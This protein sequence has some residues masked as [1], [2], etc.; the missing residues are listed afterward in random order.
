MNRIN[1]PLI[2]FDEAWRCISTLISPLPP[3]LQ[4]LT[5]L[6]GYVLAEEVIAPED[7]PSYPTAAMDGYAIIAADSAP[8][9]HII[10]EQTAGRSQPVRVEIGTAVRIMTGAP[11]P[12]GADAVIR[13]EESEEKDGMVRF[14]SA[15]SAGENI[16]PVGQDLAAGVVVLPLG[17]V[18]G[19]AEIGLL[20]SIGC[21]N[22]RV[23]PRP[24]V[25][26]MAT[27]SELVPPE[28]IPIH[29]K[30]R[31]SNSYI[32]LAAVAAAGGR[33][34]HLGIIPDSISAQRAAILDGIS[35]ADMV[36][37]SGGV[38]MGTHD[39][40]KPLLN[41][42]G[43][44]HFGQV[45]IKPGK[46]FTFATVNN[47]PVF[48][49]PGFPVSSFVVVE[50]F[51]RPALRVMAGHRR[52]W[53]PTCT[54][55]LRHTIQHAPDRTE[56]QRAVVIEQDHIY[57]AETT[58]IQVSSRLQSLVGANA[59]LRIPAGVADLSAGAEVTAL[60]IDQPEVI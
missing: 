28:E 26:V 48:G 9:R 60:L 33:P 1:Y 35:C 2:D 45:A 39:F 58:G 40:V 50:N 41:E 32:L 38:S 34:I 29:G 3:I 8:Y 20:A 42:L 12:L 6:L 4:P 49:L 59:L 56:F 23:Y 53:R 55:R 51:I 10:A 18:L 22:V 37:V 54:A 19:P 36:L 17:E 14:F 47:V 57:W 46:P 15:V 11:L 16:R 13:V 44:L 25:A 27:G 52:L 7:M 24:R 30:I 31:D 21:T 43:D 5:D